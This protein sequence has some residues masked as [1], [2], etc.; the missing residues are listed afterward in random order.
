M[1]PLKRLLLI[2]TTIISFQGYTR[3]ST[4]I[5]IPFRMD[6]DPM[7]RLLL[8]NFEND[9][10]S[11]YIGFEPQVFDDQVNGTGH[12]IIGWRKDGR[13]DV[14]HEPGL[15]PVP[16]KFDIAGKGLGNMVQREFSHAHYEI[17]ERGVEAHYQ[18]E[19]RYGRA[20]SI[21]IREENSR[22]RKPFGLLAPM[23]DAAE[24]PSAMPLIFLHDFY[25]VRKKHTH[26]KVTI[27]G[28]DHQ[29]DE[30]PLPVDRSRMLFT[31]YSPEPLIVTLNPATRASPMVL[32]AETGTGEIIRDDYI[33]HIEWEGD[34][35]SIQRM[36]RTNEIHPVSLE[37]TPAFP[38]LLK[39]GDHI[40][41][42]GKFT[43][44]G[45][46]STGRMEGIYIVEKHGDSISLVMVP[47]GGWKPDA[48]KLSLRFLYTVAKIFRK[49]PA[50]YEWSADIQLQPGELPKMESGWKRID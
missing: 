24:N 15:T 38:D 46:P 23:G 20:V 11:V 14:Y 17:H 12:L 29:P 34:L 19:D 6:I 42:K 44:Y 43:L 13:V 4:P 7:K 36:T 2:T 35:P 25:F 27:A 47:S 45:H 18:F 1:K 22:K 26:W 21:E 37:F 9:P 30:L 31:R 3:E 5:I 32:A 28:R 8:V 48:G 50:T 10:D 39:L 41:M 40:S 33:F 16:Q 49:W